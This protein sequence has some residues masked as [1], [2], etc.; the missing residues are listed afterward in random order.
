MDKLHL[1][2][3]KG[4]FQDMFSIYPYKVTTYYDYT[5]DYFFNTRKEAQQ[6]VD[7][8]KAMDKWHKQRKEA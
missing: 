8:S 6:F 7:H 5:L 3:Q 2:I 1:K 4:K